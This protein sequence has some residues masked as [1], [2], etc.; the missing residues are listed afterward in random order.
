M[1]V[2]L[3]IPPLM[4]QKGD[5]FGS[6]IPYM[7]ME[8]PYT[9]AALRQAGHEPAI[10]DSFGEKPH[11]FTNYK[12]KY[13]LRGLRAE[14]IIARI[15]PDAGAVFVSTNSGFVSNYGL[16]Y[17]FLADLLRKLKPKVLLWILPPQLG[18]TH[19]V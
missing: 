12:Q 14:E 10:V 3:V 17:D 18:L 16:A 9:A 8:V 19:S 15:R 2:D 6:G 7:S 11:Q 13:F 5:V 1:K 4:N